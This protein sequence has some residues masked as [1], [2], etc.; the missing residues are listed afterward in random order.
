MTLVILSLP[1]RYHVRV[2]RIRICLAPTEHSVQQ[3]HRA[4]VSPQPD[5]TRPA[6]IT[7]CILNNGNTTNALAHGHIL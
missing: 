7:Q 3:N 1:L 5:L 2:H 4:V 6:T